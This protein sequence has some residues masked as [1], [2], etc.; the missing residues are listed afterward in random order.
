MEKKSFRTMIEPKIFYPAVVLVALMV[1]WA[2]L[3][4]D[5]LASFSAAFINVVK[6][7]FGWYLNLLTTVCLVILFYFALSKKGNIVIGGKDAKPDVG[8]FTY[9]TIVL[10][11]GIGVGI[12]FWCIA[13]PLMHYA[14]TPA[15]WGVD[16]ESPGAGV[17]ALAY[18]FGD[19]AFH[20]Y[21]LF[22][23][24]GV[25]IA[26]AVYNYRL[27]FRTSSVLYPLAGEKVNGGLGYVV[28]VVIVVAFVLGFS[29]TFSL[30]AAQIARGLAYVFGLPATSGVQ[31]LIV[32]IMGVLCTFT[33]I[34]GIKRAIS[35]VSNLNFGVYMYILAFIVI[36]GPT[37]FILNIMN[38]AS[39]YYFDHLI[40]FG[41]FT[42]AFGTSEGWY[43]SWPIFYWTWFIST[44]LI[45]GTFTAKIARGRT[46]RQVIL[47]NMI[48]PSL[49]AIVWFSVL[50]GD[51]IYEEFYNNAGI[52][53]D[54][55]NYGLEYAVFG[56]LEKLPLSGLNI[57]VFLI[58][59]IL[60]MM[61]CINGMSTAI[62]QLFQKTE[63]TLDGMDE[64]HNGAKIAAI[65]LLTGVALIMI[66]L[67][68]ASEMQTGAVAAGL[69]A[70]IITI[71]CI[72]SLFK[73]TSK[74][75]IEQSEEKSLQEIMAADKAEK[76]N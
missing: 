58:A 71:I 64:P 53:D 68:G 73:L 49:F 4:L 74:K 62:S 44:S 56:T 23:I 15:T 37:L 19:W 30:S 13:E 31:M 29:T 6:Y 10:T 46:I 50:G 35:F 12:V 52:V 66:A 69:P 75:Y 63:Y 55:N 22:T 25:A 18:S 43:Q 39:S 65:A 32:V 27:P 76:K 40:T 36:V 20:P 16:P 70:S 1:L 2:A 57:P 9:C 11:G 42:D 47:V 54:I 67:G 26:V 51:A 59:V 17:L 33:C 60:S 28:D 38:D 8:F 5:S 61:T 3:S 24:I 41:L 14:Y 34:S 45:L 7:D 72:I 21:A 48:T